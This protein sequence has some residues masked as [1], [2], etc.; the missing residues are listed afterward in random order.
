MSGKP[1]KLADSVP[2]GRILAYIRAST[3]KQIASPDVQ[4]G[5]ITEYATRLGLTIDG[6]YVD[7]ATTSKFDL[8]DRPAGK[9]LIVDLRPGD[10]LIVA[11]LDRLSRSYLEFA[12]TLSILEKRQITLHVVDMPGGVFDPANPI[13]MLLI[14]ILVSFA[15]FERT[16]IRTRTREALHALKERGEKYCR[17]AEYGWRWEKRLDPRLKKT[18][19]V[20]VPDESERAILRRVVE[21]RDAGQSLDQIRQHL[22]YV[23]KVRTRMGGEWTTARIASLFDQGMRLMA[24]TAARTTNSAVALDNDETEYDGLNNLENESDD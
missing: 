5:L 3:S 11:K 10:M 18:I 4:K 13:S 23:M 22:S 14:Q 17:W 24:E 19:N 6:F 20:K 15:N 9:R 16:M 1:I 21:L 8:F 12:T 7:P 2:R